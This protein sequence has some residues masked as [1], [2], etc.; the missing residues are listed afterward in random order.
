MDDPIL[1]YMN[2]EQN[3]LKKYLTVFIGTSVYFVFMETGKS[4]KQIYYMYT[5]VYYMANSTLFR[6]T[7][8]KR[9]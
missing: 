9:V 3:Y 7:A 4:F 1:L 8:E 2:M 5:V 6:M